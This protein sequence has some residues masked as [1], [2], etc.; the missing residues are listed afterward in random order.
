[1]ATLN[2]SPRQMAAM[3]V[4]MAGSPR[5]ADESVSGVRGPKKA[6]NG[7]IVGGG[8]FMVVFVFVMSQRQV[9]K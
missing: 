1:M 6:E 3:G 7:V 9:D 4:S 5:M 2:P 8:A